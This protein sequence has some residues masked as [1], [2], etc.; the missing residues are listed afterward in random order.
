M[1]SRSLSK[2]RYIIP[3]V[4]CLVGFMTVGITY[5]WLVKLQ[6]LNTVSLVQIPS[7]ITLSGANR[8]ELQKISMELTPDDDINGGKVTIRRVFCIESTSDFLL[9]VV[10]TTNISNMQISIYPVKSGNSN[11]SSGVVSG[12]DGNIVYYYNPEIDPISGKYI[13]P[14]NSDSKLASSS[15][16]DKSYNS[17]D[18]VQKNAEPLYWITNDYISFNDVDYSKKDESDDKISLFYRYFV[19]ELKW[20]MEEQETD[21]IYLMAS[22]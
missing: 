17:D 21:I 9:E 7:K 2:K 12:S 5:A 20:E 14:L 22:Q 19:L 3:V 6:K 10:R 15:L 1:D 11:L 4:I 13:N 16:H 8:S 18:V